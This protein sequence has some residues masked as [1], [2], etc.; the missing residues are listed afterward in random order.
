MRDFDPPVGL[1]SPH[2]Q[3]I[4]ARIPAKTARAAALRF[5]N[6]TLECRDNARLEARV[7]TAPTDT[8]LVTIIHGWLGD[9]GSWYVQRTARAL[10]AN[11]FRVACLLLRDHGGTASY[12]RE[13]FNSAR[14]GEVLDAC[15]GLVELCDPTSAGI[16]GF[17]LGGN[18]ALRLA[19]HA[20]L[21]HRLAA[22]LAVSPVVDPAA[23]V[24][25]IDAGWLVYRKWFVDKWRHALKEKQAAFPDEYRDLAGAMRLSTVAGITDYLVGRYLPYRDSAHYYSRYDLRGNGLSQVRIGTHIIAAE[26]DMVIPGTSYAEVAPNHHVDLKMF[27]HGGHCGFLEDWRLNCYLDESSVDFFR[28]RLGASS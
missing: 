20:D 9:T 18:F 7:S 3:T 1:A 8:P 13:M 11:G 12:N 10:Q 28:A 19:S 21:D 14:L 2:V 16:M 26:D 24:R 17:S 6:V 27:R 5:D 23:T 25:A 22:C 4:L 15:N